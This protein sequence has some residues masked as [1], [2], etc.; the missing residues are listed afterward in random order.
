MPKKRSFFRATS[1]TSAGSFLYNGSS[2]ALPTF[3]NP[4]GTTTNLIFMVHKYFFHFDESGEID[5]CTFNN[6][7]VFKNLDNWLRQTKGKAVLAETGGGPSD[8][9]CR[10]LLYEQLDTINTYKDVYLGWL[11]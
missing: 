7:D 11:G 10:K 5:T 8:K 3:K 1:S 9:G 4:D 2:E 6:V